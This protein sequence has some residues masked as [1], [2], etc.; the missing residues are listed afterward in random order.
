MMPRIARAS[1]FTTLRRT[2]LRSPILL[3][4]VAGMAS[5]VPSH[6]RRVKGV[7]FDMDGTLTEHG[8]IDFAAMY[9][10][11]GLQRRH[12]TDILSLINGLPTEEER[13]KAMNVILEE[14]L[15][16]IERM[17]LRPNLHDLIKLLKESEIKTALS[18]R[19]CE[20]A[21]I[22][23][24]ERAELHRDT[25]SPALHR[26]SLGGI[27]K[28]DPAV[29]RHVLDHWGIKAGEEHHVWFVGDSLDDMLCGKEAGCKTCLITTD[30][31]KK[32]L[33]IYPHLVDVVVHDLLQLW[34]HMFTE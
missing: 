19:N 29:A 1:S 30:S 20:L 18:T 12:N 23:F 26:D 28:P 24:M 11:N 3:L 14:E 10:R 16:G 33:D 27:N 13:E 22:K 9:S 5:Y 4:A 17:K 7:I 2:V 6:V 15:L 34:D 31:N 32:I 8:S 25:F 21:Y